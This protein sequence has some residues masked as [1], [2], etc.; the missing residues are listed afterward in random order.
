MLGSEA[1]MLARTDNSCY[2]PSLWQSLLKSSAGE[3]EAVKA[4]PYRKI[5]DV[6]DGRGKGTEFFC[7]CQY[8]IIHFIF[9][10]VWLRINVLEKS[11]HIFY[12]PGMLLSCQR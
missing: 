12:I 3:N 8:Q 1:G 5:C 6:H 4:L 2:I 7:E 10:L 9:E 11:M